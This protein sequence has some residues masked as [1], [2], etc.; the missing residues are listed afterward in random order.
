MRSELARQY[1]DSPE[2]LIRLRAKAEVL[3]K[4][5][6]PLERARIIAEVWSVDPV[7]FIEDCLLI[8]LVEFNN[9]IKPF[10]LFQYQIDIIWKLVEA[11]QSGEDV[12]MLIDK[13]R[14][15]GM[16]WLLAAY[17]YW[18]WRFTPNWSCMIMSR[19]ETEVDDGTD[20]AENSIFGKL[21][22]FTDHI[23]KWLIPAGYT[24]KIKKGTDT[25]STLRLVNPEF[26]TSINGSSTNSNAGRSRRYSFVFIDECF[27]IEH[28]RSVWKALQSVARVKVFVSSVKQGRVAEE[29]KEM[30][31]RNGHHITL[32]WEQHPWK[33]KI[34]FEE[35]KKLSEFDEDVMKELVVD[36][37]L[38]SK[39]QYYPQLKDSTVMPLQYNP[40]R[41]LYCFLD[42]GKGDLTVIG[43]AQFDGNYID[44]LECYF[45]R[46]KKVT[47]YAP[48]LNPNLS[49]ESEFVYNEAQIFMLSKLHTWK[50][51]VAYFGEQ[52]HFNKV[53]PLNVSIAQVLFKYGIRLMCNKNAIQYEPRRHATAQLLPKM[54]FN[55][56]S[57]GVMELYDAIA[58]SRYKG[59]ENLTSKETG[60]KPRHDDEIG[61]FRA[62][63]ENLCVNIPRVIRT[64]REDIGEGFRSGGFASSLIRYLKI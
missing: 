33:D 34:W 37:A 20:I 22:F 41:P 15:M 23:P 21:R 31:A 38:S 5:E 60:M 55:E 12:E 63:L 46:E 48:F 50:K 4:C 58:Q 18:R 36:Y 32:S 45:N 19:T 29:F 57:D 47:W 24:K 51:P 17:I 42:F 26:K 10:F 59:G 28:F 49:S 2:Y 8:K 39:D 27:Y 53:M 25:D 13:L 56:D 30:C 61:D 52:A 62:A 14:A 43:W 35:K 6:D 7:R 64:Q 1:Y 11:E 40:A 16:T 54:R 9:E 44:I 3:G